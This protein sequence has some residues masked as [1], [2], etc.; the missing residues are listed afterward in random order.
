MGVMSGT[1]LDGVDLAYCHFSKNDNWEFEII[2]T[3]TIPYT[4]VWQQKITEWY[5]SDGNILKEANLEYGMFL[6]R[7]INNFIQTHQIDVDF[8]ASHGHTILHQPSKGITLQIGDGS[9]IVLETGIPVICNFR[10]GDVEKGGQGAPLVPIGDRL[11]F[12]EF[13]YCLNLGGFANISFEM[14]EK[15]VAYDICAVNI[16]LN[17][18]SQKLGKAYDVNGET[19]R[20]G[21][22]INP[23]LLNLNNLHY[24][25]LHFPKSL[26]REWVE[27]NIDPLLD[28][29]K[30]S[31]TNLI[32]TY[33]QHV[34]NQIASVVSRQT[35]KVLVTGGGAFNQYLIELIRQKTNNQIVVP[36]S[37]TIN[38]KEALIF[39]FL[40]VLRWRNEIN[41]LA[42]VT[43][44][45]SDS[46]VGIIVKP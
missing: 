39:A 22:V 27:L 8:I 26:G 36:D 17:Q 38:Y 18:L 24:Y 3:E 45:M 43:G 28:E 42:S 34:A 10:I 25:S 46:S 11:L 14:D 32:A 44:A 13:E 31:L 12:R 9:S 2:H 19:A 21:E 1:S 23:L 40:G 37:T 30:Y 5:N 7:I 16:V 6:G 20:S 4:T 33:T 15:R 41:C 29:S 35:G